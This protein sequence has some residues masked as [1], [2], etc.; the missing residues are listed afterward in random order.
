[1]KVDAL[2]DERLKRLTPD[3]RFLDAAIQRAERVGQIL[4]N[5]PDLGV[6]EWSLGGSCSKM[7]ALFPLKDVDLFVY[8]D[9]SSWRVRSQTRYTPQYVLRTFDERLQK[10]F[11]QWIASG[12]VTIR[13]QDHSLRIRYAR[14]HSVDIDVVPA[15]WDGNK[16]YI[17]EIPECSTTT[18]IRTCIPRQRLLLDRLDAPNRYLRRAIRLLKHWR[19]V[20]QLVLRSYALE[21]LAAHAVPRIASQH[22]RAVFL[23]AMNWIRNT[24]MDAPAYITDYVSAS[25]YGKVKAPIVILDPAVSGNNVASTAGDAARIRIVAAAKH[26]SQAIAR[27]E[28]YLEGGRLRDGKA[29]FR[30]AF[31]R[32]RRA[33]QSKAVDPPTAPSPP[34]SPTSQPNNPE[35][36]L[37]QRLFG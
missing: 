28:R 15:L 14:E 31:S 4:R 25:E 27:A 1:M 10:T 2:F 33:K 7:T 12:D 30:S 37:W 23:E 3:D 29:A 21:I 20:H 13:R 36:S 34:T 19:N 8:L 9:E 6:R 26:T 32:Q 16:A 18:W 11:R 24:A 17:V 22:P 5:D 35:P